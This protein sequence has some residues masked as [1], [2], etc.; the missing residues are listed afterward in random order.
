MDAM[1]TGLGLPWVPRNSSDQTWA[2]LGAEVVALLVQRGWVLR[3]TTKQ[4][5]D[6]QDEQDEQHLTSTWQEYDEDSIQRR[7]LKSTIPFSQAC[8][9][10]GW[11]QGSAKAK[12]SSSIVE[13]N[14]FASGGALKTRTT[15]SFCPEQFVLRAHSGS[16]CEACGAG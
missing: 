10:S 13:T 11:Q 12:E 7:D 3:T 16:V 1:D 6:E 9:L 14:H 5:L 15:C 8:R 4:E 2:I